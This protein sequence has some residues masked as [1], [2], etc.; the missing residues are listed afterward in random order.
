MNSSGIKRGLATTA[1]AALAVT[2]LPFLANSASAITIND[3]VGE[4]GVVFGSQLMGIASVRNDGQDS[5][6]RLAAGGND[7]VSHITFFAQRTDIVGAQRFK[8]ATVERNDDGGFTYEW[9]ASG[10]FGN[11]LELTAASTDADGYLLDAQGL[12]IDEGSGPVDGVGT[13]DGTAALPATAIADG[14]EADVTFDESVNVLAASQQGVF[15]TPYLNATEAAFPYADGAQIVGVT[16]TTSLPASNFADGPTAGAVTVGAEVD[17]DMVLTPAPVISIPGITAYRVFGAGVDIQGYEYS[18]NGDPDQLVTGALAGGTL[19]QGASGPTAPVS[20]DIEAVTLYRQTI[21][22]VTAA[23]TAINTS[24]S[25]VVVTVNDQN[26]KPI[27]GARVKASAG[28]ASLAAQ[29]TGYTDAR[30]QVTF[31]QTDGTTYYYADATDATGYQANLGDKRSDDVTVQA[32]TPAPTTLTAASHDGEAFDF[33][34]FAS[35]DLTVTLKD[36]NGAPLQTTQSLQYYWVFDQF[37]STPAVRYPAANA[38][39]NTYSVTGNSAQGVFNVELPDTAGAGGT[40]ELYAG[41]QANTGTG[42]G[43]VASSKLLTVKAGEASLSFDQDTEQAL[44]GTST[45]ATATLEL[46]DGTPLAGRSVSFS[47]SRAAGTDTSPD[48]GI[49][50][51]SGTTV[52]LSRTVTTDATGKASVTIRD[53]AQ[54]PQ[55]TESGTL[56]AETVNGNWIADTNPSQLDGDAE[57]E[58][59]DVDVDFVQSVTPGSV[60]FTD[61]DNWYPQGATPGRPV[62]HEIQVLTGDLDP[63]TAGDQT[64]P[65][66]NGTVTVTVDHGFFVAFDQN[67]PVR[68]PAPAVGAD[69]GEWK[70]AGTSITVT[71]D[72]DG[73]ATFDVAI[74]RDAGFDDDGE[75]TAVVTATAGAVS[76]TANQEWTSEDPLNGGET[77][78][79]FSPADEQDAGNV[80][81]DARPGT[82][83]AFDVT[84]TDQFGN[85]VGGEDVR[86]TDNTNDSE[87]V[88]PEENWGGWIVSDFDDDGDFYASSE[89]EDVQNVT[90]TWETEYRRFAAPLPTGRATGL[91]TLTDSLEVNWDKANISD[92]SVTMTAS[93]AGEVAPGTPVTETVT[94]LDDEGNPVPGVAVQFTQSGPGTADVVTNRVT[95]DQGQAFVVVNSSV[96]GTAVVTAV[97]QTDGAPVVKSD[98]ITWEKAK[99]K[100]INLTAS[101]KSVKKGKDAITANANN[102]AAG[103]TATLW[104]NGKQIASHALN[105]SGDFTFKVKDQNGKKNTTKYTVKVKATD[106]TQGGSANASTK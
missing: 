79:E 54:T 10:Q 25:R 96:A 66:V 31:T 48:S 21:T 5:T 56:S 63:N 44:A 97:V 40:F 19:G 17:G 14:T 73:Y 103:L 58:A 20:D 57:A 8:I 28:N 36:Q 80:L 3:Q 43:A 87:L 62:S 4:D 47:Y 30:G 68:D 27:V 98:E 99:K 42:T 6:V 12:R 81:P 65:V 102:N 95:N 72:E 9:D 78:L 59:D 15:Q 22:T 55:G 94:V 24:S 45:D 34:E 39:P 90:A 92:E 49:V 91:E 89:E 32:Y 76:K 74:E 53:A 88:G 100:A 104:R 50:Q 82:E 1:V 67:G 84:V 106:T 38:D 77:I 75:V 51:S 60:T 70:S 41:L 46:G 37:G 29:Q 33:D 83:V 85:P 64:I 93:P 86:I 52:G 2:G 105:G 35:G 11:T 7:S 101:A 16:G 26:G 61:S 71:T 23:A 69:T 13:G 18:L